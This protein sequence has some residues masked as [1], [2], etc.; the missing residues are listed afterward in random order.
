MG[1]GTDKEK[2]LTDFG[3]FKFNRICLRLLLFSKLLTS[4]SQ[5]VVTAA[6]SRGIRD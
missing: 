1:M 3:F 2:S 4:C 5:S 6:L